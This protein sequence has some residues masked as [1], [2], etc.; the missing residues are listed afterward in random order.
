VKPI[1]FPT[2]I[3]LALLTL[4]VISACTKQSGVATATPNSSLL[5]KDDRS[6]PSPARSGSRQEDKLN[7]FL[8]PV[9]RQ[10]QIGVTYAFVKLRAIRFSIRSIGVLEPDQAN[11]FEYVARVD[12][13]VEDLKVS[14][15]GEPVTKG[16]PLLTMYSP[17]LRSTEQELVNL[18][19]ASNRTGSALVDT[20]HLVASAEQRLRRWNVGEEEIAA[21][22]KSRRASENLVLRS[23]FNGVA[24]DVPMKPGMRVKAGDRLIGVVDLSRLWLWAQFYENESGFLKLGQTLIISL[25][26]FPDKKFYGQIGAIDPRVDMIN[27]TTRVR[28]D[29]D[30]SNGELRPGMFADVGVKIDGGQG[31][32]VPVDA[33]LPTGTRRLV[34]VEKGEGRLEPRYI[35]A[36]R[37]FTDADD[38]NQGRYYQVKSGLKEGE[39]VVS[40]ANFL[41]DAESQ[42]Q[43]AVK[44]FE[45]PE[46]TPVSR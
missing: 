36:S 1:T 13:Y 32:T 7:E 23:P 26:A 6:Q 2:K 25:S 46:E 33:V 40:S 19:T 21:L 5:G 31:L 16:Q 20:D 8:V 35:Q 29:L 18:L 30:N 17:D 27:R 42:I 14:S 12:G 38:P 4:A 3:I 15:P 43:G 37:Q 28:I 39:R 45:E 10:Q 34:F 9:R 41:I 24:E 44:T 22:E 11:I